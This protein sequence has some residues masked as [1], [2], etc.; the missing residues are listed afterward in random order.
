MPTNSERAGWNP[1]DGD[2]PFEHGE[3]VAPLDSDKDLE[4][5]KARIAEKKEAEK[6]A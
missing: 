4:T 6:N 3:P 1:K 2:A 5:L